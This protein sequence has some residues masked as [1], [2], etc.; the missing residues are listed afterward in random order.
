MKFHTQ[1]SERFWC[2]LHED[3]H[4]VP[5]FCLFISIFR[6]FANQNKHA[7]SQGYYKDAVRKVEKHHGNDSVQLI[8]IYQDM[9]KISFDIHITR[10]CEKNVL[11]CMF[12]F[13]FVCFF[14]KRFNSKSSSVRNSTFSMYMINGGRS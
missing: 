8:A 14:F 12:F 13:V 11:R 2:M 3:T 5:T 10:L 1:E 7:A 9:G 6:L 4:P